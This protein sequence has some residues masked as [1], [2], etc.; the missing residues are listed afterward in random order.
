[1]TNVAPRDA[2]RRGAA[3]P[4]AAT[5]SYNKARDLIQ[6]GAYAPGHDAELDPRCACTPPMTALLQQDMHE[7]A[8]LDASVAQLQRAVPP[9][10]IDPKR[11]PMTTTC[12]P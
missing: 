12:N 7:R 1:M 6:L 9:D 8:P 11:P 10:R 2:P 5:P 3:L 4:P